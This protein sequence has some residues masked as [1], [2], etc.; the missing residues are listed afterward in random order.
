LNALLTLINAISTPIH[1]FLTLIN[2]ISTPIHAFLTLINAISTP[3]HAFLTLIQ[4]KI[5]SFTCNRRRGMTLPLLGESSM[6]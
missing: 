5:S 2:A 3:I 4:A 6:L 1:A